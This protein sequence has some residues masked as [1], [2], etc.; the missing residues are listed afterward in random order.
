MRCSAT[1]LESGADQC[2]S[3]HSTW[4]LPVAATDA[5]ASHCLCTDEALAHSA[6]GAGK[7]S[8]GSCKSEG[9]RA[10]L[11]GS[12]IHRTLTIGYSSRARIAH[13]T[14]NWAARTT[15]PNRA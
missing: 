9:A 5:T 10:L 6:R 2:V 3:L 11:L 8:K 12:L 4:L 7:K 1:D 14:R 15:V 13:S